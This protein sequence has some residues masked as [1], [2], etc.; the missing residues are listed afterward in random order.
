LSV[1]P[2]I[3]TALQGFVLHQFLAIAC[4]LWAGLFGGVLLTILGLHF[5]ARLV[6]WWTEDAPTARAV[7]ALVAGAK[8]PAEH[9]R[10]VA[11][12]LRRIWG[13]GPFRTVP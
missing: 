5:A 9:R 4:A 13:E 12:G 2:A 1:A 10:D 8:V 6:T 3:D 11:Q 7:K